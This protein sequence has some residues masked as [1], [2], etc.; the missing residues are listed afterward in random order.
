MNAVPTL[1]SRRYLDL[2]LLAG[3]TCC[4]GCDSRV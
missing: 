3:S 4:R 1:V 2:Q